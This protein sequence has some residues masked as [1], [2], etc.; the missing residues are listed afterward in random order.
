LTFTRIASSIFGVK[1]NIVS[2]VMREMGRKGGMVGG[3][4]GGKA[5]MA[6]LSPEQ[7]KELAK[8]AAMARWKSAKA[9]KKG[10]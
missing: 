6:S 10:T 9:A 2:R 1:E 7:R 5:R 8:K 3:K 4:K